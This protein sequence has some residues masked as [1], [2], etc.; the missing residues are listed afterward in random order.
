MRYRRTYVLNKLVPESKRV[1]FPSIKLQTYDKIDY[2][3]KFR[4][5]ISSLYI[6]DYTKITKQ[7]ISYV[8]LVIRGN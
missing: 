1:A 2:T 6:L 3:F 5:Y 8:G 4:F 7:Y